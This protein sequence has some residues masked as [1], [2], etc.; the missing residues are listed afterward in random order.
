MKETLREE[1]Y[2]CFFFSSLFTALPPKKPSLE[3]SGDFSVREDCSCICTQGP[4]HH[5]HFA[6]PVGIRPRLVG[7]V[8]KFFVV[9]KKSLTVLNNQQPPKT[10]PVASFS[11]AVHRYLTISI[12]VSRMSSWIARVIIPI[13]TGP[14]LRT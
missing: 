11:A 9:V 7:S 3:L 2:K 1:L 13:R 5:H 12:E 14:L 6:I 4:F 8:C 10:A